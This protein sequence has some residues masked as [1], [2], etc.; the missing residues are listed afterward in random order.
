M[1]RVYNGG[2]YDLLHAGHVYAFR[3]M[4]AMAGHQGDVIVGLNR[5]EFVARFK[6]HETVQKLAERMEVVAAI[7]DVDRVVVNFGDEDSRPI[8]E[9]LRPDV[10]AVG[11]D[12]YDGPAN[13]DW[14]AWGRYCQQMGFDFA[15]LGAR[16]IELRPLA[17]M[18]ERSSTE[19]RRAAADSLAGTMPR[20]DP[21]AG[22]MTHD[23]PIGLPR[24]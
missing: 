6:Q 2:T 13:D 24:M 3:Q 23:G 16:G 20:D 10:I 14:K 12:W 4:R 18:P 7:R 1:T 19:L 21:R 15:W 17:W 22:I 9:L 8:L 11:S 5:D